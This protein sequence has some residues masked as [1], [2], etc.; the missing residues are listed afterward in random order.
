MDKTEFLKNQFLSLR[1]EIAESKKRVF[2]TM[3][4]GLVVVPGSHFLAQAYTLDTVTLSLPILVIVVSLVYLSENNAIMRCGRYIKQ[5][6]EP[7]I[8]ETIGWEQWIED[9]AGIFDTRSV[10]KN[11]FYAF[12][13][14]FFVYFA[15]S[16]FIACR[17][18]K[19]NFDIFF[20][21]SMLG[22]YF[23]L[24]VWFLIFLFKTGYV[25]LTTNT[26]KK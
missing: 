2:Q 10:D 19:A 5:H 4:F 16:V 9:N 21:A 7:E 13:L 14:L 17:F 8:N 11:M 18:A 12:Y 23:A 24:G 3:G 22:V 1:E 15:G 26:K 25:S 6:I 20:T